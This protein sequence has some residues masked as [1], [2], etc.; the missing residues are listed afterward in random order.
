MNLIELQRALR[1]LRLGAM[2]GVLETRLRQAQAEAMPPIDLVS[3]L[4]SDG[5]TRRCDRLLERRRKQAGFRDVNKTLDNFDFTFNPKMN[6][7]LVFDLA[8]STFI[9][10]REDALFLGPGGTGKS[11]LAQ[12][13]GHAAIQQCYKVIYRE[14]HVLLEELA[15]AVLDG[16]RKQYMETIAT[17]PLLIIDDFGMRRLPQT[18]A[19]DLLEIVMRRYERASTLLT[20]NRPVED[21]GKLLGDVAAV[22]SMLDRLL[23][24]GHLL[25]CGPRSWRTKAGQIQKE[26]D[27]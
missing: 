4:V 14:T 3:C 10:K 13:I 22:S 19:E 16:T 11:H 25:K 24:H 9:S 1:Q 12:A 23:H 6:R 21:W 26:G 8:T 2:A 27:L 18:A 17:V 7:S 15:D 20:S 5:L